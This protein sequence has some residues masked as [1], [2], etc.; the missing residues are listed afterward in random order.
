MF[1]TMSEAKVIA[2]QLKTVP[3]E[4]LESVKNE[5]IKSLANSGSRCTI[6]KPNSMSQPQWVGFQ[7]VLRTNGWTIKSES[8]QREGQWVVIELPHS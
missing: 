7:N 1:I 6:F 8:C 3:T 2:E 4:F 5:I